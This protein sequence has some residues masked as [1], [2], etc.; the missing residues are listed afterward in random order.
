MAS[1]RKSAGEPA[2]VISST[3]P[4]TGIGA[5]AAPSVA[6][7][8][9][10][11]TM[12][13]G[14]LIDLYMASYAGQD[15]SRPQRLAWW[16]AKL[17][18]RTLADLTDD[19]IFHA[20][21]ELAA[22]H[23]RYWAGTDADGE[24][25][26]K[27]KDK[28]LAPATINRYSAAHGAVLSWSIKRRIAPR[29]WHNPCRSVER[30]SEDNA[31][32]RFLS[33]KERVALLDACRASTWPQLYLLVMLGLTTGARKGE[34]ENLRWRDID[35]E[36]RIASIEQTKNGDSRVLPLVPTVLEELQRFAGP[37]ATLLFASKRR[38]DKSYNFRPVWKK[39]LRAARL[40]DFRFHDLR[41]TAASY[42]AMAGATLLEVAEVLGHRELSVTKRYS[43]LA[44]EH[45]AN[46]VNRVLG[47]IK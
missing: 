36:R 32:V 25:V 35:F 17:G 8:Q 41:H 29:G 40:K 22:R 46:L 42:L 38:P 45:K 18:H 4:A 11:G 44:T 27:S 26:Y 37:P 13:L 15:V 2:S 3:T 47:G 28:P 43:H 23:G 1:V 24:T 19:D 9:R 30:R 39:A 14:K 34:L 12:S 10:D 6:F 16:V 5:P 20:L 33:D 7:A 31:R 21:E